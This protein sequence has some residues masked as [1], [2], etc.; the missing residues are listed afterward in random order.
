MSQAESVY[1]PNLL[2]QAMT[3]K[4]LALLTPH[5]ERVDLAQSQ[6]LSLA[7]E[8]IE[9]VYFPEGGVVSIV[10][11]TPGDGRTEV[12]IF[13]IEGM[14]GI[15]ILLGTDSSP[16][17]V[18]VQVDGTTAMRIAVVDL[19]NAI[20]QSVSLQTLLLRY[21]Q[22]F[23]IQSAYTTTSNAH[24]RVEARLARWLLMCHDRVQGNEIRL[25]HEFMS[26]MIAAQRTGVTVTLHILEGA[27]MIRSKRG[28]VEI[29][30]REK[31]VDLAGDAYGQPEAEY[32]R[33]IAPFGRGTE[34]TSAA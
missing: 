22:A 18:F 26:M 10:S 13:G 7:H 21:I 20:R 9:F 5:L 4:D 8:L 24:H 19:R 33:L 34:S 3:P 32:R 14:S 30:D 12:G 1:S 16:Q 17:E 31:L 29:L 27:G 28:R 6:V 23:L 11:I 25:T 15:P 2:L